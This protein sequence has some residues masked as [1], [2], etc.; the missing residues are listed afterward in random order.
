MGGGHGE[1]EA[2]GADHEGAGDEVRGEALALV[3]PGDAEGHG[4]GDAT[5]ADE[6]AGGDEDGDGR[7]GEGGRE[8]AA[9]EHERGDLWGVVE[10]ACKGH[11]SGGEEVRAIEGGFG[12]D[13]RD[14]AGVSVAAGEVVAD[15]ERGELFCIDCGEGVGVGGGL[16]N[17]LDDLG[18]G[19]EAGFAFDAGAAAQGAE[20]GVDEHRAR[21]GEDGTEEEGEEEFGT[22]CVEGEVSVGGKPTGADERADEGVG[23]GDGE[24][25]A[26]GEHDRGGCGDP[27][28]KTEAGHLRDIGWDEPFAF[29]GFEETGGEEEGGDGAERGRDGGP[30]E[31]GAVGSRVAAEERGDAFEIV[32]GAIGE[33]EEEAE[34]DGEDDFHGGSRGGSG[35]LLREKRGLP[36]GGANL[37]E[38]E[39]GIDRLW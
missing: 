15:R 19:A 23:S 3:E 26:R 18:A 6:S 25:E 10:T 11:E 1:T 29:E 28:A 20:D 8:R 37:V 31:S 16:G 34:E 17:G 35:S 7:D 36:I 38:M 13:T 5:G 12:G 33:G 30:E 2:R 14:R 22:Q 21:D 39:R 24:A 4:L 27:D 32:I 9:D